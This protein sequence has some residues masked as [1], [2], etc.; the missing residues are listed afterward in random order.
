MTQSIGCD[1]MIKVEQLAKMRRSK[2]LFTGLALIA[3]LMLSTGCLPRPLVLSSLDL[4]DFDNQQHDSK[5]IPYAGQQ[6]ILNNFIGRIRVEGVDQSAFVVGG[7]FVSV[8]WTT[9]VRNLPLDELDVDI[10]SDQETIQISSNASDAIGKHFKWTPPFSEERVGMIE[11]TLRVPKDARLQISQVVGSIEVSHFEG[12]LEISQEAG[13]QNNSPVG[14]PSIIIRDS[15]LTE[16]HVESQVSDMALQSTTFQ[17]GDITNTVGD[18]YVQLSC[19]DSALVESE[20]KLKEITLNGIA[21]CPKTPIERNT[22]W[23]GQSI[24]LLIGKGNSHLSISSQLGRITLEL[25]P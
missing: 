1:F 7:L 16:L 20:T 22:G 4:K 10:Q 14:K 8:E 15:K 18:I 9:R 2:R 5:D 17:E 11:Y 6:I 3:L 23:P 25:H 12:Q 24:K 21:N 13:I 19:K